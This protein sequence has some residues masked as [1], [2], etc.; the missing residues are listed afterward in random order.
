MGKYIVSRLAEPSTWRGIIALVTAAGISITPEQAGA[1]TALG[2]AVIGVVGA[3]F[4][5]KVK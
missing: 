2:L 3:F 1:V 4:P 5:D